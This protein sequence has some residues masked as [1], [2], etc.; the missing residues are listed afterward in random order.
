M[1]GFRVPGFDVD[2]LLSRGWGGELWSARGRAT[3]QRVVLRRLEVADDVASHDRVRRTAARLVGV[4]HPH[5]GGLRGV[6]SA[7][8]AVVLVHDHVAGAS[9][10]RLV[11]H[12]PLADAEVV[13]LAVPLADALAA[14]HARGLAHGRVSAS[15]VLIG[16]D[17]RP[18][19]ADAGVLAL[20]DGRVRPNGPANDVRDLALTC[21]AALGPTAQS[22]ALAAVLRVASAGE[23]AARPTATELAAAVFAT[24]PAAPIRSVGGTRTPALARPVAAR[25]TAAR[26][27]RRP[28]ELA[29]RRWVGPLV[30]A[31][32]AATAATLTGLAWAGA[33]PRVPGSAVSARELPATQTDASVA[34]RWRAVLVSLDARRAS[35]FAA[36]SPRRLADVYAP[37][38]PAL[39]RDQDRLADVTAAGLHVERLHLRPQSLRVESGSS[40]RVVLDVVDVLEPYELRTSRGARTSTRPG[41]AAASWRVT[42]V[43]VGNDWRVY[44][45]AAGTA[46][47]RPARG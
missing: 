23:L 11:E 4:E 7:Q 38:A 33:D 37:G 13:T 34:E 32:V 29:A 40:V 12:G 18:T 6:L 9:L 31:A 41:R 20:L 44:D 17:G 21:A 19:L 25:A 16:D 35:A 43:R 36:A 45:V 27:H 10:E 3:G 5:L 46:P 39:R 15:C 26:S 2:E 8:G 14:L 22:S 42:L 24:G 1:A 47:S 30:A 28:A